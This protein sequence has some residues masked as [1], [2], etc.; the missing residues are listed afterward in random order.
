[1]F[2]SKIYMKKKMKSAR[3]LIFLFFFMIFTSCVSKPLPIIG[4]QKAQL[5]NLYIEYMNIADIYFSEEKFDKAITY[6]ELAMQ[7]KDLY[8]NCYY[9]LAKSYVY[10]SDW[11]S[12]LSMF[13]E[14]QNRDPENSSIK[15]SIAYIYAMKGERE[16]AI[17]IYDS[18]IK[19]QPENCEFLENL[20]AILLLNEDLTD[21]EAPFTLLKTNFPNS[22]NIEAFQSQIDQIIK[23][24]EEKKKKEEPNSINISEESSSK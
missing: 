19:E 17:K 9:K 3:N 4:D 21:V 23:H 24:N 8:W 2:F 10:Q 13:E 20:I 15:E 22:K 16:K 11:Q 7:N 14:L 5:N 18:L 6:Y 12:A 1:M